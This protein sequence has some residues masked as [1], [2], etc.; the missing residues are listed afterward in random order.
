MVCLAVFFKPLKAFCR[1]QH[2]ALDVI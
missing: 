2:S 1:N